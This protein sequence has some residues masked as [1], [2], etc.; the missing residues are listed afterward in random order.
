MNYVEV[1][2]DV[3]LE[4]TF[5]YSVP[6]FFKSKIRVGMR[7]IV[8]VGR[9]KLTGFVIR[10]A[11]KSPLSRTR[12]ILDVVDEIPLFSSQ[13]FKFTKK[14]SEY[15]CVP[16]IEV[17]KTALPPGVKRRHLKAET[18]E[19][20]P[21][22]PLSHDSIF[23]LTHEQR[24]ALDEIRSSIHKEEYKTFLLYGIT[25]SGKT[26]VYL[27]SIL[28]SLNNN[29]GAIFLV[30]EISL[31]PQMVKTFRERFG[32]R[33]A[34]YHSG[35]KEK[36]RLR[37]WMRIKTGEADIV[38]GARSAI[39]APME[40]VGVI[41]VDESHG[42]TYKQI[43]KFKYSAP[44]AAI[45]R[46]KLQKAAVI[47]GS[48][49]P[50][51]ESYY[52]A[53]K[54]KYHL[55]RLKSRVDNRQLPEIIIVD[56]RKE[57]EEGNRGIIS[58]R[59]QKAIT[60]TLHRGEQAILFLNRRGFSPVLICY[61]C[62]YLEKC[63]RCKL[64]LRYHSAQNR[65]LCHHCGYEREAE[66]I[67]PHCQ[68][69]YMHPL[70][71]G[72]QQVEKEIK[73]LFPT[74][75]VKRMDS[76]INF[77]KEPYGE[78]FTS[79]LEGKIDILVGTQMIAKGLHFPNVTLVG[80]ISAD[81]QLN[82]PHFRAGELT[83]QLLTQVSGRT[84]RGEKGGRVIVQTYT[85]DNYSIRFASS[86][87]FDKFYEEELKVRKE[88]NYP[89]FSQLVSLTITGRNENRVRKNAVILSKMLNEND[90]RIEFAGPAPCPLERVKDRY[91]WR[92][93]IK[94]KSAGRLQRV[95]QR[96]KE[97]W[98]KIPHKGENLSVDVDPVNM[99]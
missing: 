7:V 33:I 3:P 35:L 50:S 25:G 21:P 78:I 51:V 16:W 8:P 56:M 69:S 18:Q 61:R 48:A 96:V 80:I 12:Q 62:G 1:L 24:Q 54:G 46:G 77:R 28:T 19:H 11:N 71:I 42:A 60:E 94:S 45:F 76:D 43:E 81:T 30:P 31:T 5:Y 98:K 90:K 57:K 92:I 59:L 79:F 95:V 86:Y 41:V 37:E 85:P 55:I 34:L 73:K 4:K 83:F 70:G 75:V 17:I 87:D 82:L 66:K 2:L 67:C 99:L 63:I 49:T 32:N 26:Q 65:V 52:N 58:R 39:F 68:K 91:R 47:M 88:L 22:T 27:E 40:K 6:P 72:T 14:L 36:E 13:M 9:R 38:L 15:Y 97:C 20:S 84:G 93:I 64:S 89:P 10:T 53:K 23:P 44:Q 74:C 29:R